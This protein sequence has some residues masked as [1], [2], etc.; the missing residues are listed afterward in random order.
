MGILTTIHEKAITFWGEFTY[1]SKNYTYT[2]F[3]R[4]F[5]N[6]QSVSPHP[7]CCVTLFHLFI[8]ESE[9]FKCR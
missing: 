8:G 5:S 1:H 7:Q 2:Y 4:I 3:T 9:G 6:K